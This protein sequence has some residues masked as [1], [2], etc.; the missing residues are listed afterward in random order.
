MAEQR[1]NALLLRSIAYSDSSLILHC[2]TRQHGRISLMARGARRAKSP[3]RAALMP[4]YT[5]QLRWKEPRTGTMGTLLEVQRFSP[6]LPESM[7]LAG[8]TLLANA[9]TLFP[10]GVAHGYDELQ[11]ACGL[12]SER[13]EEAGLCVATWSMLE[14]SGWIGGF[15]HCWHCVEPIDLNFNMYWR[16]GHLL[17][18]KCANQHGFQLHPGFRKSMATL[19]QNP[20]ITLNHE[21]ITLWKMMIKDVF[22]THQ[23]HHSGN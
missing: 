20:N 4:L 12:L 3:F 18:G 8:Q 13:T 5:L 10:D 17:C 11:Q 6:L 14:R 21:H 2:L 19:M 22:K 9:S 23:M 1:D 7:I 16:Q 15:N